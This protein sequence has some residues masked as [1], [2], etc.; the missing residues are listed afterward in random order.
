MEQGNQFRNL[1]IGDTLARFL[2]DHEIYIDIT[3]RIPEL[4]SA[5]EEE[6]IEVSPV[7]SLDGRDYMVTVISDDDDPEY[8]IGNDD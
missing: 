8:F 5:V 7:M 1:R 6:D 3:D 2:N 4:D